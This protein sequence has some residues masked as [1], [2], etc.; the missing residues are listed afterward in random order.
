MVVLVI[1]KFHN[2]SIKP[3]AGIAVKPAK[4]VCI[5]FHSRASNSDIKPDFAKFRTRPTLSSLPVS[6][7]QIQIKK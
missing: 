7:I 1:C 5:F 4:I 2:D 6:L 3:V